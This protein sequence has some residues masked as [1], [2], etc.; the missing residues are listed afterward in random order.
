M[1]LARCVLNG[2]GSMCMLAVANSEMAELIP[3]L[4][5][6]LIPIP[7]SRPPAHNNTHITGEAN[8]TPTALS[9]NADPETHSNAA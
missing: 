7:L 4:V 6:R 3:E 9:N 5:A 1:L 2:N 8:S